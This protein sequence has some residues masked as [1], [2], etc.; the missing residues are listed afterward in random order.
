MR[1]GSVQCA[2]CHYHLHLFVSSLP[3]LHSM[4][5]TYNIQFSGHW[6]FYSSVSVGLFN[7]FAIHSLCI[8]FVFSVHPCVFVC[9]CMFVYP[10]YLCVLS[11]ASV[12]VYNVPVHP[13]ART[14]SA[15]SSPDTH[16]TRCCN[17]KEAHWWQWPLSLGDGERGWRRGERRREA[18]DEM[19]LLCCTA[20]DTDPSVN[21]SFT[22]VYRRTL[23]RYQPLS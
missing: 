9:Q 11:C 23:F 12:H 21:K 16:M 19:F 3:V 7:V 6:L 18:V 2:W 10:Q 8:C 5:F 14:S 4:L 15:L 20:S 22:L 17:H 1:L 13:G